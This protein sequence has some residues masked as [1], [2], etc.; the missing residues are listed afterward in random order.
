MIRSGA[1]NHE[2]AEIELGGCIPLQG[3]KVML[4][5]C[6]EVF[7]KDHREDTQALEVG[8]EGGIAGVVGASRSL[9]AGGSKTEIGDIPVIT[10]SEKESPGG[11][12]ASSDVKVVGA[13]GNIGTSVGKSVE[14]VA[15][16]IAGLGRIAAAVAQAK[17]APGTIREITYPAIGAGASAGAGAT[18]TGREHRAT[19]GD[20]NGRAKD[21]DHVDQI[22][23]G[24][25]RVRSWHPGIGV[26]VVVNNNGGAEGNGTPGRIRCSKTGMAR[27]DAGAGARAAREIP[28]VV[29]KDPAT[30]IDIAN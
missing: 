20:L 29:V 5:E 25:G 28:V 8:D 27:S 1:L 19:A 22:A 9:G 3:G 6:S 12:G 4:P 16:G 17:N 13:T 2:M 14:I 11:A 18:R 23:I 30:Q 15:T 10:T 24:I 21:W 26:E 7:F